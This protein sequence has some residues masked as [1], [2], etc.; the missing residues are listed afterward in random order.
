MIPRV[1][2]LTILLSISISA[3]ALRCSGGLVIEGDGQFRVQKV[4]GSPDFVTTSYKTKYR[5]VGEYG[6]RYGTEITIRVDKWTYNFGSQRLV[7]TLIF[8][9]GTLVDIET[10]QGYGM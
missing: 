9:D 4:C 1:L 10:D 3:H 5:S 7:Y 6:Y 2:V 8:E